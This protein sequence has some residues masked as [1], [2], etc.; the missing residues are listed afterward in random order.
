MQLLRLDICVDEHLD[1]FGEQTDDDRDHVRR[2]QVVAG[3]RR[4]W[5]FFFI[6][7]QKILNLKFYHKVR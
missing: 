3:R 5:Q 4:T 1:E 7:L 6:N 2:G